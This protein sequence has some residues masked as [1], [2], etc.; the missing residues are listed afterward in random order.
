MSDYGYLHLGRVLRQDAASG[1]Y[2]LQSVGLART[3]KW[4]PVPSC[5]PGLTAGDRVI[6]GAKGTSRDDLV[7]LAKIGAAFP[8]IGDIDGLLDALNAK[9]NATDLTAL[10]GTVT[11]QG[12]LITGLTGRTSALE[13]RATAIEGVNTAQ[14]S[15]ISA[16]GTAIAT[17]TAN[18]ATNTTALTGLQAREPYTY[19]EID[20]YGDLLSTLPRHSMSGVETIANG[21]LYLY[22]LRTNRVFAFSKLRAVVAVAGVG[23]TANAAVYVGTTP[24]TMVLF[25]INGIA[26]G[27]LGHVE[28]TFAGG[29]MFAGFPYVA[30]GL[31]AAGYSSA[32]QVAT[33]PTVPH[34]SALNPTVALNSVVTK[35][36]VAF[37]SGFDF[38]DGTWTP[39]VRK[40]WLALAA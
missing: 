6:L 19:N 12:G 36:G 16:N 20:L 25:T 28:A 2:E 18:I 9:A 24:A 14:G 1:G 15:A 26:L 40:A 7:I 10:A 30:L 38:T 13:T 32:P 35:A 22:K 11:S 29:T 27:T 17:N 39:G 5:V 8:D 37:P 31:L 21:T 34:S 3:S 4:G 33:S 23:G